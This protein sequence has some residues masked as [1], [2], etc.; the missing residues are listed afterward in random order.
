VSPKI[1]PPH[2]AVALT[3]ALAAC[4]RAESPAGSGRLNVLLIVIDTARADKFGC[5][6]GTGG[7][8]P[9]ID[10]LAAEGVRFEHAA[11]HA[12]WTLPSTASLLTSLHPQE[13]GA[14][15]FLDLAPLA[16]GGPPV[17]A[18]RGLDGSVE[19]VTEVFRAA[20]WR[21]GAIVN[22]DF[23]DRG[24]GLTQGVDDLDAAWYESNEE[25]RS[26]TRTTDLALEW[27]GGRSGEPFFLLTHYFDTHAVYAPPA[28]FRRRFA[29]P[30]DRED[31]GFVFGTREHLLLLRA[32]RLQ[33]EPA[34]IERAERLYEAELAYVD[35]E[36]GR[37]LD[38]LEAHGLADDTL[39]VL[40]ADHGEEFLE[41]GGFEHGHTLYDELTRVPLVLR[42]PGH[43]ARGRVVP[44]TAALIDVAPTLCELAGLAPPAGFVGRSLVGACRGDAVLSERPVLAHGNFW[45]QPLVSWRSG[46]WKLILTPR[47]AG[48]ESLELYDLEADPR[49][50]SELARERP[51]LVAELRAEYE[52]VRAHLAGRAAGAPVELDAEGLRRLQALGYGGAGPAAG[53]SSVPRRDGTRE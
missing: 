12:P 13:H 36:V 4:S 35:S 32:G 3:F 34:L 29:A 18:F 30:R 14:G 46:R 10:R 38:G 21:T 7:L 15:G 41:H 25:V 44:G 5:Y 11:A 27:L 8:T 50:Q 39:V 53:A 51:A 43:L 1:S 19:T 48:G 45:G 6:G 16:E 37:L 23:L 9:Q 24:F 28:E 22:V 33:L 20:G 47:A 2:F 31:S 17:V 40:T 42:L 26:A 49:E 52:A